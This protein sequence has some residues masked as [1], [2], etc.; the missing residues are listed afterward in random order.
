MPSTQL[1]YQFWTLIQMFT[2]GKSKRRWTEKGDFELNLSHLQ[3][4]R[5]SMRNL[6]MIIFQRQRNKKLIKWRKKENHQ[7]YSD[8]IPAVNQKLSKGDELFYQED[9]LSQSQLPTMKE[10]C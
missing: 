5:K 9:P 3:K 1:N 2:N 7:L 4:L 6:L 10:N 8:P